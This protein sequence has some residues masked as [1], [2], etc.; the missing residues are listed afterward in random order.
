MVITLVTAASAGRTTETKQNITLV[1]VIIMA[2]VCACR[3]CS[4]AC[5]TTWIGFSWITLPLLSTTGLSCPIA[6]VFNQ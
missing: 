2:S 5:E 1:S 4:S 6:V 3:P